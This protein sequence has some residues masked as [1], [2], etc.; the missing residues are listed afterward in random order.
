MGS[1]LIIIASKTAVC[2]YD[3]DENS[4]VDYE[5]TFTDKIRLTK[6][7]LFVTKRTCG[8]KTKISTDHT[9]QKTRVSNS[10]KKVVSNFTFQANAV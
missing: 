2:V 10:R 7:L 9:S 1:V 4:G 3:G 6:F 5:N 8:R